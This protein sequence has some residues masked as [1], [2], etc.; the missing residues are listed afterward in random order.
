MVLVPVL[1][2]NFIN[3]ERVVP[4]L[5]DH[6]SYLGVIFTSPR[7]VQAVTRLLPDVR[8]QCD[9][10]FS[11]IMYLL[12]L[13]F[14]LPLVSVT[15]F[16]PL[17]CTYFFTLLLSTAYTTW[18]VSGRKRCLSTAHWNAWA[19]GMLYKDSVSLTPLIQVFRGSP[20]ALRLLNLVLYAH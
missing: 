13:Y 7:S 18:G 17:L 14:C 5:C 1:S 4:A 19:G 11:F 3:Q 16:S 9:S 15:V 20:L 6:H 8:G 12:L 2:F 10:F